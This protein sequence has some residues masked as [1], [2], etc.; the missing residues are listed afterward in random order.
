M[1]FYQIL[2]QFREF[3]KV[4]LFSRKRTNSIGARLLVCVLAVSSLFVIF[5]TLVQVYNDYNLGISEIDRRFEQINLSYQGSLSR[6]IWEV[7]KS[8][9]ESTLQGMLQLPDVVKVTVWETD[10]NMG[11]QGVILA[12]AGG[13]PDEGSLQKTMPIF[14]ESRGEQVEI[15]ALNVVISLDTLYQD[16]YGTVIFILI[17]QLIKTFLMFL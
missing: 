8:Q 15:G 14:I 11:A 9:I 3:Y 2:N 7:N 13:I 1:Y 10:E 4:S 6:S 5:Q 12:E 17:F 16:L